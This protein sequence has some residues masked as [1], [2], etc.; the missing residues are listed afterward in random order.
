MKE[1]LIIS[2]PIGYVDKKDVTTLEYPNYLVKGSL[3]VLINDADQA[4]TRKGYKKI[5][6]DIPGGFIPNP[7]LLPG[8]DSKGT[9]TGGYWFKSSW[10]TNYYIATYLRTGT[11]SI[12]DIMI[13]KDGINFA[14]INA[15][16]GYRRTSFTTFHDVSVGKSMVLAVTGGSEII[17]INPAFAKITGTTGI[18]GSGND[19]EFVID[20]PS[21]LTTGT[22]QV[23]IGHSYEAYNY[24]VVDGLSYT[25]G[26]GWRLRFP[27]A[28]NN[29][30]FADMWN[31]R[32]GLDMIITNTSSYVSNPCATTPS[33]SVATGFTYDRI[34]SFQNHV[35]VGCAKQNIIYVSK[36]DSITDFGFST[37]IARLEGEGAKL[38]LGETVAGFRV[39][40]GNM[41]VFGGQDII[42]KVVFNDYV[43]TTQSS[44]TVVGTTRYHQTVTLQ[45]TKAGVGQGAKDDA[46]IIATKND[47]V[48]IT[49]NGE[50]DALSA[51]INGG[52]QHRSISDIIR[53]T[54]NQL[55]TDK[56]FMSYT[57]N[58]INISFPSDGV[59]LIFDT[60]RNI[61]QAP[62]TISLPGVFKAN[63]YMYAFAYEKKEVYRIF[64][65]DSDN[66]G[67]Y[68]CSIVFPYM[69]FGKRASIKT[70]SH[71][72]TELYSNSGVNK[73]KVKIKYDYGSATGFKEYEILGTKNT[74]DKQKWLLTP[75]DVE[76]FGAEVFGKN[77]LA[78]TDEGDKNKIVLY[79]TLMDV[80]LFETQ[81]SLTSNGQAQDWGFISL[82][83]IYDVSDKIPNYITN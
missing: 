1:P 24:Q 19:M 71:I 55:N 60:L 72:F 23:T 70:L 75:S 67:N 64:Y 76:S 66:G 36:V 27:G 82:G 7:S 53:N 33:G 3:N 2:N 80:N 81:I 46:L 30:L 17:K 63:G 58:Q 43:V 62:Q 40:E 16:N 57:D 42:A 18:P 52:Q 78:S 14:Y 32:G 48:Y 65:G 31:R 44:T 41:Y 38:S 77:N 35:Y 47:I 73:I 6:F 79:K 11:T 29:A 22:N 9:F 13:S 50:L 61:W 59:M 5:G 83:I 54:F 21:G 26:V 69:Q 20:D 51:V 12:Y 39:W 34:G 25:V 68:K 8:T 74:D 28:N 37:S 49:A 4:Q 56:A 45:N 10:G 15:V